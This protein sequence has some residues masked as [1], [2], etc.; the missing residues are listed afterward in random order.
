MTAAPA[1]PGAAAPA[2]QALV[3]DDDPV[4]RLVL[5]RFLRSRGY[6]V[7]QRDDGLAGLERVRQGG[8]QL[9]VTD[10][11]MPRMDGLELC[12]AIRALGG[13]PYVYCIMLTGNGDDGSLVEAMDAGVDDFLAKPV[14][15]PELGARLRA[16]ERV[17]AL[18][19]GLASRNHALADA[20]Q[21]LHGDLELARV[22]QLGQLPAAGRFG[23]VHFD[24]VFQPSGY[25][26]GDTFDC[27]PVDGGR[28]CFYLA[29]VSGHGVAAAM[30]AFHVQRLVRA[31]ATQP[32]LEAEGIAA[33]AVSIVTGINQ[34]LLEMQ[35]TGLFL[36]M[37]FGLLEP[38]TGAVALVQAGHPPPLFAAAPQ[39]GFEAIGDG[40]VPL[41]VLPDP[42]YE[43]RVLRLAPGARLVLYSDG[44]TD[45][46]DGAGQPFGEARLRAALRDAPLARGPRQ[47]ETALRSWQGGAVFDDDV[48]VLAVGVE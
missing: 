35:D 22:L 19:A 2:L 46:R 16:A 4:M 26:G 20:Y 1:S 32:M 41:G 47:L 14:K 11:L 9:V 13:E 37:A 23:P 15:L 40:S 33:A 34:R 12:R 18:Q 7:E 5:T 25:V 3:V 24:W 8:I 38:G 36:T 17:L 31:L 28:L 30:M 45:C 39:A 6:Q 43:A 29:D 10:R 44:V 21:Q 48:T 27:F 42:G